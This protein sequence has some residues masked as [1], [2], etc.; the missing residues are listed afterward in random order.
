MASS[1]IRDM[2][3]KQIVTPVLKK[4]EASVLA[5]RVSWRGDRSYVQNVWETIARKRMELDDEV[6]KPLG[7]SFFLSTVTVE[8]LPPVSFPAV[9]YWVVARHP[10]FDKDELIRRVRERSGGAEVRKL[11]KGEGGSMDEFGAICQLVKDVNDMDILE[12]LKESAGGCFPSSKAARP[13]M[14]RFVL[15]ENFFEHLL[16]MAVKNLRGVSFQAALDK[17]V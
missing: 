8:N 14:A 5:F 9:G 2:L 4:Q 16:K 11:L 6:V 17:V 1:N 10:D 13:N 15:K 3:S 7:I 12:Q